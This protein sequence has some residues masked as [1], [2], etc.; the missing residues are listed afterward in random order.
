ML[1]Q[2]IVKDT[3]CIARSSS[4]ISRKLQLLKGLIVSAL[5]RGKLFGWKIK[6]L[7]RPALVMLYSEIFARESYWFTSNKPNPVILDCGANIGMAT[8]YFKWL[9]PLAQITAFEP[10]P[11]TFNAL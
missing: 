6:F 11:T 9:Y 8:L 4:P 7:G 1:F 10:D 2:K 3:V 5:G